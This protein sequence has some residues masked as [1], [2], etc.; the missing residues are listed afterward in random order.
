MHEDGH[1][2]IVKQIA[3]EKAWVL[4]TKT[5]TI[6]DAVKRERR[7]AASGDIS[8]LLHSGDVLYVPRNL[9]HK[10]FTREK[11]SIHLTFGLGRQGRDVLEPDAGPLVEKSRYV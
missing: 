5:L 2:V 8:L 1:H 11:P 9:Q 3:G 4:R 10:A 6:V 7:M